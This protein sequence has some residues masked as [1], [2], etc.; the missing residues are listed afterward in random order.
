FTASQCLFSNSSV[1]YPST[2][3][4]IGSVTNSTAWYSFLSLPPVVAYDVN[5][6]LTTNS[7]ID[8]FDAW[9]LHGTTRLVHASVR[10]IY[11]L[12]TSLGSYDAINNQVGFPYATL[13]ASFSTFNFT[14]LPRKAVGMGGTTLQLFEDSFSV[15][16]SLAQEIT[17]AAGSTTAVLLSGMVLVTA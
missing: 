15:N 13:N 1:Y 17:V 4:T 7:T 6:H 14:D 16:Y 3:G 8:R 9:S 12:H 2:T 5:W 10:Y 11:P